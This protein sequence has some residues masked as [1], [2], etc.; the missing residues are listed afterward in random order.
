MMNKTDESRL[1]K[2]QH[3]FSYANNLSGQTINKNELS[4]KMMR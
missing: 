1:T 4:D 2:S 3:G